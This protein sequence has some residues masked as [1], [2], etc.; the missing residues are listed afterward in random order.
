MTCS[1]TG[2]YVILRGSVNGLC[3]TAS[4]DEFR[5]PDCGAKIITG[6]GGGFSMEREI[7]VSSDFIEL[8][9]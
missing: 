3:W 8:E 5:C 9:Q 1:K 4:G 7:I 2:K 6:F